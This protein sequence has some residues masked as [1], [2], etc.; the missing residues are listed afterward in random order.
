[1]QLSP[2]Q[3]AVLQGVGFSPGAY[4][5]YTLA[6]TL[7]MIAACLAVSALIAWR[8]SDDR[9]ALLVALMLVTLSPV[10]V[11]ANVPAT[12][13][14]QVPN[15][16]LY[17]LFVALFVLVFSLFPSGHFVPRWA[18][19]AALVT[20]AGQIPYAFF[21]NAP[22]A[23]KFLAD[24]LGWL[25]LLGEG[26]LL[27]AVQVYR[28]RRVSSPLERQQT[29]WVIVGLAVPRPSMLAGRCCL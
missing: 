20:L 5:A 6:L 16:W 18:R 14:V 3:A 9:M 26:A 27:V 13:P 25:A 19:W 4:A 8:R 23:T 12:S 22:F 21:P 24:A 17:F 10:W 7:A 28:Y 15:K 2:E 29:K 11:T 1:V